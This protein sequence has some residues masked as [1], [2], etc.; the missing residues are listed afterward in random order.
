MEVNEENRRNDICSRVR[1]NDPLVTIVTSCLNG[2]E[3]GMLHEYFKGILCQTYENIQLIFVN[4]GST[5]NT[6]S[7]Y[8]DYEPELEEKF[9]ESKY[10]KFGENKGYITAINTAM[11]YAEGKY[12]S[13][14]DSDDI[15]LPHKIQSHVDFLEKNDEYAMVYSD[16]YVVK[17]NNPQQPIRRFLENREPSSGDDL[18]ERILGGDEWIYSGTYCF[19]RKCW[20]KIKPL[21]SEFKGRGQ[22]FQIN[23][24]IAYHYKIGYND[25]P[26][27]MKYVVRPQSLSNK[28]DLENLYFKAIV[29]EDL[30]NHIIKKYGASEETK[31]KIE[32][33]HKRRKLIYY[34]LAMDGNKLR[35]CYFELKNLY[36]STT[37][38]EF[39]IRTTLIY[40]MSMFPLFW[41]IIS[42]VVMETGLVDKIFY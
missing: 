22:N 40:A 10:I 14:F 25:V 41:K 11:E 35:D 33:K 28:M 38:E 6:E 31:K 19:K 27:V 16:G 26:P 42:K 24:T 4:D 21:K 8:F 29:L 2:E 7:I 36:D 18:Y 34:F 17:K 3:H 20:K 1:D 5:D 12:I 39:P 32:R 15:M 13:P 23:T 9:K 30:K 37:R